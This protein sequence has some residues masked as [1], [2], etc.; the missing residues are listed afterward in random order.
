MKILS[1]A[2]THFLIG[3]RYTWGPIYGS[4]TRYLSLLHSHFFLSLIWE[5]LIIYV[6]LMYLILVKYNPPP[7]IPPFRVSLKILPLSQ[8]EGP[9]QLELWI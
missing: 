1:R 2:F 4:W 6:L 8:V 3:P 7:P 9:P 5:K